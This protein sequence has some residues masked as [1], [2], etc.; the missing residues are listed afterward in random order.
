MKV[1]GKACRGSLPKM[2]EV[3]VNIVKKGPYWEVSGGGFTGTR[4]GKIITS[5]LEVLDFDPR[6]IS[7]SVVIY[8]YASGSNAGLIQVQEVLEK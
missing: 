2:S 1:L 6:L 3:E 4:V 8:V 5:G 7:P